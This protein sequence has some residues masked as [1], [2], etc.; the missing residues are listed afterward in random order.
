[1]YVKYSRKLALLTSK[2][3]SK[4]ASLLNH[5]LKFN[6]SVFCKLLH[7]YIIQFITLP[8]SR[9]WK[10]YW[11]FY[12]W[13]K[14]ERFSLIFWHFHLN[15]VRGLWVGKWMAYDLT[16]FLWLV[17]VFPR[18]CLTKQIKKESQK[19]GGFSLTTYSYL[20]NA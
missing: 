10:C 16:F 4:I 3:Y 9:S 15:P 13:K 5:Y 18:R 6:N 14:F 17:I 7:A 11:A 20:L 2:R 12:V 1:M 19:I 8:S